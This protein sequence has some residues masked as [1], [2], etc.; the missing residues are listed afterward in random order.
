MNHIACLCLGVCLHKPEIRVVLL[1]GCCRCICVDHRTFFLQL[2][3]CLP[4]Q[5]VRKK[6]RKLQS[7][8]LASHHWSHEKNTIFLDANTNENPSLGLDCAVGFLSGLSIELIHIISGFCWSRK[9]V[10][11]K[12]VRSDICNQIEG[13]VPTQD[14]GGCGCLPLE[15]NF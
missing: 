11:L 8:S 10:L 5:L 1:E 4:R 9:H 12:L 14:P 3:L 7:I 6:I 13:G 15:N 2:R